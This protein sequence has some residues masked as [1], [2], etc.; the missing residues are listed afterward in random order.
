MNIL[1]WLQWAQRVKLC[2][3]GKKNQKKLKAPYWKHNYQ[4]AIRS[5]KDPIVKEKSI[6][7]LIVTLAI[8]FSW[9]EW[10]IVWA[11]LWD[12]YPVRL[13]RLI[14]ILLNCPFAYQLNLNIP[15]R[16]KYIVGSLP[17]EDK[18]QRICLPV[19]RCLREE[20]FCM[21]SSQW[22]HLRQSD[23]L[24]PK[25]M[26]PGSELWGGERSC[27]WKLKTEKPQYTPS[28]TYTCLSHTLGLS[29]NHI[30]N[31]WHNVHF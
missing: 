19:N 2:H 18:D 11:K 25:P 9:S 5:L 20:R 3:S 27:S 29:H 16:D 23:C 28:S 22:V 31:L 15:K 14:F 17:L 8:N 1:C 24:F 30:C 26:G 4:E 12:Y 13:V 21:H 7:L 6:V 10:K